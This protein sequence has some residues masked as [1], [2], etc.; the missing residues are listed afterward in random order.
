MNTLKATV[1][2][3][4]IFLVA[5]EIIARFCPKNENDQFYTGP[6]LSSSS[7][8]CRQFPFF[9]LDIHWNVAIDQAQEQQNELSG[10]VEEQMEDSAQRELEKSI[11][12]L[13]ATID[14]K[15]EKIEIF[16]DITDESSIVLTK[17]SAT[18]FYE[19][20]AQRADALLQNVLGEETEVE[21][22]I[23]GH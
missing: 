20:D 11:R 15:P 18:F 9:H 2:T 3:V 8:F 1:L 10:Y 7:D 13:L 5:A 21:V 23:D 4:C 17:V 12:G 16:T 14:L 22:K 6:D 19:S